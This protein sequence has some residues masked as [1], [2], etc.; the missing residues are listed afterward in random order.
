M[1]F[2]GK[3]KKNTFKFK[4]KFSKRS[5]L[6]V[7]RKINSYILGIR[8]GYIK[9]WVGYNCLKRIVKDKV[10]ELDGKRIKIKKNR[11]LREKL[12]MPVRKQCI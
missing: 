1:I 10:H 3:S 6:F 11:T 8:F 2:F 7:T 5:D 4:V 9:C 12:N